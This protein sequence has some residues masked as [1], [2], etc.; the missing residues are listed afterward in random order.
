MT[1]SLIS[2][3]IQ[4]YNEEKY[5]AQ[6]VASAFDQTYENLEIILSDN[7][8]TDSSH[9]IMLAAAAAYNGPHKVRVIKQPDHCNICEH[10][11]RL[12]NEVSGEYIIFAS[13]D[14]LQDPTRTEKVV[15]VWQETG[16]DMIGNN[17]AKITAD[18]GKVIELHRNPNEQYHVD[19]EEILRRTPHTACTGAGQAWSPRLFDLHGPLPSWYHTSDVLVPFWGALEGGAAFISEPLTYFRITGENC[20][21]G[22]YF[23]QRMIADHNTAEQDEAISDLETLRGEISALVNRAE[24]QTPAPPV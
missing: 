9:E 12:V 13:G 20:G 1:S 19:L 22:I 24:G 14:D 21:M 11:N 3:L 15:R 7:R 8:S 4:C 10:A 5:I 18:G 2:Y 23:L 16:A 6:A 17:L